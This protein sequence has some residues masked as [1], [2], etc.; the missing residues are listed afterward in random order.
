[1]LFGFKNAAQMIQHL[2]DKIICHLP[3]FLPLPE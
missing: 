3:I 2:R 1:M